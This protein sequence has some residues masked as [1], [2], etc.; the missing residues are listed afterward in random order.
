MRSPLC[1]SSVASIRATAVVASALLL[2]IGAAV[3][4]AADNDW[5]D[6][7]DDRNDR[8]KVIYSSIPKRLPGNIASVGPE[9]YAFKEVGDG[10]VFAPGAGGTLDDVTVILSSWGCKTGRWYTNDCA[11][12]KGAKFSQPITLNVYAVI[13]VAGVP[14]RGALLATVS[15]TF[16][17]P[18]R[19]SVNTVK[20]TGGR[21]Y[22]EKEDVCYNGLAVPIE[23][24]L[25]R[26]RVAVP[27]KVIVGVAYNSTHYGYA[28]IGEATTCYSSSGGCPYDSLNVGTDGAGARIG[29]VTD[30]NG[31]FI[32]YVRP[33]DYCQPHVYQGDI[34][35]LDNTAGCWAGFHPQIE[36][37]S[38]ARKRQRSQRRDDPSD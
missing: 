18:Y 33:T 1:V 7:K 31:I 36:V 37:T 23:F 8:D 9:A 2:S 13:D 34:M 22:S 15:K 24:D 38:E 6:R 4:A 35:Q 27:A 5:N 11:T 29:S 12:P 28:P 21:W 25:S 20:C 32:N 14:T 16:D 19:P 30:P 10:L 3:T 26:L 17:I